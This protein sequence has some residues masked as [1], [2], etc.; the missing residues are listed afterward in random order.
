MPDT[1]SH[2]AHPTHLEVVLLLPHT[3]TGEKG[4]PKRLCNLSKVTQFVQEEL[5]FQTSLSDTR[6]FALI[7]Y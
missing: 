7:I 4:D 2:L 6:T 1:S 3:Y 5:V